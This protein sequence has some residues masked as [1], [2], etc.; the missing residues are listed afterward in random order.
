MR[1]VVVGGGIGG[2]A[3]AAAL[4]LVG[5][6]AIVLE[7]ATVLDPVGAGLGLADNALRALDRIGAGDAVRERGASAAVVRI[8]SRQGA[9]ITAVP[10]AKRGWELLGIHRADLQEALF[11]VAG[12]NAV[13]LGRGC[14]AFREE[15]GRVVAELED[16]SE[17]AG[18][19]LVGADGIRST[20][21]AQLLADG[22]PEYAGYLGWRAVVSFEDERLEGAMSESWG[23]GLRF[24]LV[25]I[26]RG[27]LYWFASETA[28]EPPAPIVPG[29]KA[30]LVRAAAGWH[31]PIEAVVDATP[32]HA[33]SGTGIYWRKP[34]SRWGGGRAT[35]LGDAAHPMTPDIS[36]GAAQ[37]LED[38][39]VLAAALRGA[40]DVP[41][42]LRAYEAARRKRTSRIVKRSR[43]LGRLAQ[44]A[45]PFATR[46]RVA[47]FKLP[48]AMQVRQQRWIVEHDLP[49]LSEPA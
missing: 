4:R 9:V 6:E 26:G 10:V 19:V 32:E 47:L 42:A 3:A 34:V 21:R 18:D 43:A 7:H 14:S 48:E 29:R 35:L 13:H 37:A 41:A 12:H 24:G 40:V 36:Q 27:R 1:A 33:I 38:A 16:G 44:S 5:W 45:N 20:L 22:P 2:L 31:E 28:P 49:T 15:R 39:V 46:A 25:P 17:E 8:L 11:D 30:E 23:S